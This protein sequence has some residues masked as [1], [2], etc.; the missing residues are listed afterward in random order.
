MP[1]S[2]GLG[3]LWSKNVFLILACDDKILKKGGGPV[4]FEIVKTR[5]FGKHPLPEVVDT[6]G[7]RK[8]F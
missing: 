7:R 1:T 4:F 5:G 2:G 8:Y 3:D 6:S